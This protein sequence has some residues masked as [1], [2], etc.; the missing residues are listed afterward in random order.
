M[1]LYC[2]QDSPCI[3]NC[4]GEEACIDASIR[5]TATDVQVY[6]DG[7]GAC[8]Q[9]TNINCGTGDCLVTCTESTSCQYAVFNTS[10]AASFQCSGWCSH[11]NIPDPFIAPTPAPTTATNFP[12]ISP[13][14]YPSR[15]MNPTASTT[16][17]Q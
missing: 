5:S 11:N 7:K 14:T 10:N 16:Q 9:I 17:N 12:F 13:S 6:C 4:I 8:K 2:N 15:S 1:N 3:I